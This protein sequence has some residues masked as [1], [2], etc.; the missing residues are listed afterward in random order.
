[1]LA[2]VAKLDLESAIQLARRL[3]TAVEEPV[4]LDG[5]TLYLSCCIGFVLD[6]QLTM[7]YGPQ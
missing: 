5:A 7:P 4:A 2:P 3:Q 1:M 6:R